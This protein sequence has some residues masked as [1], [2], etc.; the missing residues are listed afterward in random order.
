MNAL[1][2]A[3]M[4]WDWDETTDRLTYYAARLQRIFPSASFSGINPEDQAQEAITSFLE[5]RRG[6]TPPVGL[7]W[8]SPLAVSKAFNLHMRHIVTSVVKN[9]LRV[10]SKTLT[11]SEIE[12]PESYR[13]RFFDSVVDQESEQIVSNRET[14]EGYYQ[15]LGEDSFAIEVLRT[16]LSMNLLDNASIAAHLQVDAAEVRNAKRRIKRKFIGMQL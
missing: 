12:V 1:Q 15:M 5:G 2:E 6:W 13:E 14:E 7:D 4:G 3:E 10:S 9:D 8:D 16:V 11:E